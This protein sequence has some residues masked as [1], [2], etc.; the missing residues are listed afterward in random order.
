MYIIVSK[1]AKTIETIKTAC[2]EMVNHLKNKGISPF[3]CQNERGFF[4]ARELKKEEGYI[5]S[6]TWTTRNSKDP[7]TTETL[8][9]IEEL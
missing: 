7:T 3:L 9:I 6:S 1:Y 8:N 4:V 5:Y 2:V